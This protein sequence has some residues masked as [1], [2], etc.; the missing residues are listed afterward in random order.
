MAEC[1]CDKIEVLHGREGQEYA[2]G[3]LEQ[4]MV[5]DVKWIV[6]HRCP[7]TG[8]Y[9]IEHFPQSSGHAGGPPEFRQ[10]SEETATA[11]FEVGS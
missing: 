5:N 4:L 9:W 11:Q 3:H 10:I 2:R 1:R 8:K 7:V 6:L